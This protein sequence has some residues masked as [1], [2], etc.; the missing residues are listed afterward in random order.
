MRKTTVSVS[1]DREVARA[2]RDA[3]RK[4]GKKMSDVANDALSRHLR[5]IRLEEACRLLD[6]AQERELAEKGLRRDT[7][8]WPPY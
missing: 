6:T 4:S 7:R 1:L 2:L 8:S 5:R 3:A